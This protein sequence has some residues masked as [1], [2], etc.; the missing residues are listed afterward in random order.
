MY[1]LHTCIFAVHFSLHY[2][3]HHASVEEDHRKFGP[4]NSQI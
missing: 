1:F 2:M 3:L 4:C